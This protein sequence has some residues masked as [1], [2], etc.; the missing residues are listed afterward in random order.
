M[1]SSAAVVKILRG[2]SGFISGEE[3]AE[4][5]G[6]S[7]AAVWKHIKNL[8]DTGFDIS[9]STNRGYMLV[10]VPD[11]PSVEVL[12]SLLNTSVFGSAIEY[13]PVI[14]STNDRAM[15]LG[16]SGAAC[17][18]VVT[19]DRQ[20]AGKAR[21]GGRWPSPSG[22][23]L[24]LSIVLHPEV[25]LARAGEVVDVALGSLVQ[26]VSRF[27]PDIRLSLRSN[28]LFCGEKKLGGVLC[29]VKG[30]I[31]TIHHMAAGVGLNV[32]HYKADSG[33]ESLFSLT[34]KMLSRA[35]LTVAVIE[36]FENLYLDWR[37][38]EQAG[39]I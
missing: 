38:N 29:E 15:E 14:A 18:T 23:N 6:V 25:A 34:G 39:S 7:R 21:S 28:G 36:E 31:D 4:S 35:E 2:S 26:A 22:K 1:Q 16:A 12:S 19:A 8:R 9:A 3:I 33:T 37:K 30:E 13:H 5:L 11:V 10:A 20:T 24:Y 32:S 17:G 27:F